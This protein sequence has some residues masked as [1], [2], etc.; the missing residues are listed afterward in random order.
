MKKNTGL[1]FVFIL[2]ALIFLSSPAV[3]SQDFECS[4]CH[5]N[6]IENSVHYGMLECSDCHS[7]VAD[8]E[9][10]ES[11]AAKVKCADCHDEYASLVNTDIHHRLK[12]RVKNPPNCVTC[13]GTHKVKSPSSS[14]NKVR[15]YCSKCHDNVVLANPYH[16]VAV[17]NST[18]FDCHETSTS[19]ELSQS[20]HKN[21]ACADCHNYISHNLDTHLDEMEKSQHADCYMCHKKIAAEHRESIHGISLLEGIDEAAQC[22][23]CHGSHSITNVDDA[24]SMV[25]PRNL[26]ETCGTCHDNPDIMGK[27][28]IPIKSP[29]TNYSH[30]VHGKIIA[31][32]G[33][34]A[35]CSTCHGV[36]N[37][38]TRIAP[39][40]KISAFEIPNTCSECHNEIADDYMQSIH[41]IRAKQGVR[42]SPVC[43]DCH[44]EHGIEAITTSESTRQEIKKIQERTCL[45]CHSN[46]MVS[47]NYATGGEAKQYQD[48]YHGLAVMRGDEDAAMCVDCHS[49]HKILPASH[50]AS[51]V[52]D[53]NI[54]QTCGH[55]HEESNETFA[56]S[57]SHETRSDEARAIEDMV[58]NVY[59]WLIVLVIGGMVAHNLLIYFYELR[60]KKR[61]SQ[62]KVTVPRM[63]R[64][65]LI[66]HALL[67][68]SFILLAITGFALKYPNSWWAEGLRFF[69][70][71][72][73]IRQNVHRISAVVMIVLGLYHVVY[74]IATPRG[75]DVLK[76]LLP[77][78]GDIKAAFQSITYYLGLSK[79]HPHFGKYDYAEKAEYWALIWGTIV[80]GVTGL[81]LWFP[82]LV[83]DWAP[84]WLIKVSETIHFYEAILASLA[85]VVWHWF[86]VILRPSQYPMSFAWVTGEIPLDEY[87]EH[88]EE[89]FRSVLLEVMQL[90]YDEK[91]KKDVSNY[92]LL[93]IKTL[94]EQGVDPYE[95]AR[96]KMKEDEDLKDWIESRLNNEKS[97]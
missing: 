67:L 31:E 83:G 60:K 46:P 56:K 50:P 68:T 84:V 48:S 63:T 52:N 40:S 16:S 41:W 80:M 5:D 82:T 30:S 49:V 59:F 96:E 36:H 90:K 51:S 9:H 88:H 53:N 26:P 19:E 81:I 95:L 17:Q 75:R 25:S 7:D 54:V 85:I 61:E 86:F 22:W 39:G 29:G 78:F 93:L 91:T 97:E 15:D 8:E 28:D 44:S 69:G 37:I 18:C 89:H 21:L 14:R 87:R 47:E 23:D 66:Q 13:H 58:T 76:N 42:M 33:E 73:T 65:E 71:T 2:I 79:K 74:L 27:F 24:K 4:D 43:T 64:N 10:M 34:A 20:I 38:Q 92:A 3:F 72:E 57:Y 55:C 45:E 6:L 94:K 12:D 62:K 77:N 35:T 70:M 32:G 1:T 11:G